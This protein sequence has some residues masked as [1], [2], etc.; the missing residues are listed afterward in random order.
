MKPLK[1]TPIARIRV[2]LLLVSETAHY[3]QEHKSESYPL[4]R[5]VY[6]HQNHIGNM[7]LKKVCVP[8]LADMAK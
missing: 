5:L 3:K 8:R 7:I 1:N 6:P 2:I 4:P